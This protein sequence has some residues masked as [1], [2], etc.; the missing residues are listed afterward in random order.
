MQQRRQVQK[1]SLSLRA[2]ISPPPSPRPT[3]RNTNGA[4]NRALRT[5]YTLHIHH[6]YIT[7][8]ARTTHTT[9][10]KQTDTFTDKITHTAPH[11]SSTHTSTQLH[12][13]TT[14]K[15]TQVLRGIRT[16]C[17][18]WASVEKQRSPPSPPL[19]SRDQTRSDPGWTAEPTEMLSA[20]SK[21][22]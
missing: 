21:A 11:T 14:P 16:C 19:P 8:T 3:Q 9:P 15:T 1:A 10:K 18:K 2:S 17:L 20:V 4:L 22:M 5:T 7:H 6:T 13:T 12:Y